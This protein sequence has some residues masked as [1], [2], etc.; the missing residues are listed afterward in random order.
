VENCSLYNVLDEPFHGLQDLLGIK[1]INKMEQRQVEQRTEAVRRSCGVCS[2]CGKPLFEGQ[3]QGAH[4]IGNTEVNRKKYGYF[5]IDSKWDLE[6]TC[7]L[8]CNASVDVGKSIGNQLRVLAEILVKETS[9]RI[10]KVGL[11]YITDVLLG[12]YK[13][14][15]Y[16]N[17]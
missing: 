12:E 5:F 6:Y 17:E 8:E 1:G 14:L 7:C 2:V 3:M 4:K 13:R 16:T 10:G 11:D 15:G 9:E